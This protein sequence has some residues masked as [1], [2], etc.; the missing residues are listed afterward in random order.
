M[1][2]IDRNILT[3]M[4]DKEFGFYFFGMLFGLTPF[5]YIDNATMQV[6][7]WTEEAYQWKVREWGNTWKVHMFF[8]ALRY[9]GNPLMGLL[10]YHL[11]Q[12]GIPTFY[13]VGNSL[14]D[15]RRATRY[16]ASGI[17]TDCPALLHDY[18][19]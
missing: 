18:L 9:L 4:N 15:F 17:M 10:S 1:K 11:R 13:W 19:E 7:L 16:G 14:E 3:F 8:K 12:R 2:Q 5:I 6:P